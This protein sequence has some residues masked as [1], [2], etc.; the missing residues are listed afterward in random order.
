MDIVILLALGAVVGGWAY[1]HHVHK[2]K[3][4]EDVSKFPWKF[5]DKV[6]PPWLKN[7]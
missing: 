1:W 7:N 5:F 4:P 3:N 6:T 2:A